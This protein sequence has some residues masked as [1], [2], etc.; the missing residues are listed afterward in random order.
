MNMF[1]RAA[2]VLNLVC[3]PHYGQKNEG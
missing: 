1:G 3:H 2:S